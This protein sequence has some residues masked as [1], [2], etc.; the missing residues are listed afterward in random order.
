MTDAD[1]DKMHDGLPMR[2]VDEIPADG[3]VIVV[4][5]KARKF[6]FED[7]VWVRRPALF[8][9][10][11]ALIINNVNS[12]NVAE[13]RRHN[14]RIFVDCELAQNCRNFNLLQNVWTIAQVQNA[15]I[16]NRILP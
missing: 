14:K 13:M 10:V 16:A 3:G 4:R 8:V 2:I 9:N 15:K 5:T 11:F 7:M 1:R 12:R 6:L